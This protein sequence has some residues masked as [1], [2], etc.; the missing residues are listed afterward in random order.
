MKVKEFDPISFGILTVSQY[1]S[2]DEYEEIQTFLL[3]KKEYL[4]RDYDIIFSYTFR[5]EELI[6]YIA[7]EIL[8]KDG[9]Q[10]AGVSKII[11]YPLLSTTKLQFDINLAVKEFNDFVTEKEIS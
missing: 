1:V 6:Y 3:R 2:Q 9:Y 11:P 7:K 8:T 10:W 5:A 4:Q